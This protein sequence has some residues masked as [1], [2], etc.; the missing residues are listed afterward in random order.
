MRQAQLISELR[1]D[2]DE[3]AH[4]TTDLA[5]DLL[6]RLEEGIG[7]SGTTPQSWCWRDLG[8]GAAEELMSQLI[9]WVVW[10]RRGYPLAK[11]IPPCWPEHPEVI[12]EMTARGW[13]GSTLTQS[14]PR[15]SRPLSNGTTIGY[16]A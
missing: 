13:R 8:P 7:K 1:H 16:P 5:A 2:I 11:K 15:H 14:R 6:A 3:L 9:E 4:G 12:E 10:L